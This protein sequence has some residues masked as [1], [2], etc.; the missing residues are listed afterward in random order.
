MQWRCGNVGPFCLTAV[1]S[2]VLACP[3]WS[4]EEAERE[5][6][7]RSPVTRMV[8]FGS[9]EAGPAKTLVSS[10]VKRSVGGNGLDASGF[11]ALLK[12][13]T[14]R[15]SAGGSRPHGRAYK[16]ESQLLFGYEWH[17]D[18]TVLALYAGPDIEGVIV[19]KWDNWL[20]LSQIGTRLH[21][22][23]WSTP[24]DG[25]MFQ[26]AAYASSL[27]R[28]A[29]A[30]L[31][32]GWTIR[33]TFYLGPEIELYRQSGYHQLRVGFHLTGLQFLGLNWRFSGGWQQSSDDPAQAY[34]VVGLHWRR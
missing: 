31:A 34:V 5:A 29:W 30:R 10:G 8:L 17:I 19:E 7:E 4:E 23:L 12:S 26:A 18:R 21:L 22:D 6:E 28:R 14:S 1:V 32:A 15:E 25:M 16:A 33:D 2:L 9:L 27:D 24:Q 13:G 3:A 20:Y 11:R